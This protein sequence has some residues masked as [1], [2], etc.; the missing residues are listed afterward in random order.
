MVTDILDDEE[1]DWW[2]EVE[3]TSKEENKQENILKFFKPEI[4]LK[5]DI[6]KN[7]HKLLSPMIKISAKG[8]EDLTCTVQN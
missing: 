5:P 4:E 1:V 7:F 8:Y 6:A 2:E 3:W